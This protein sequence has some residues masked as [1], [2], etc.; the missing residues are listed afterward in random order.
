M[1]KYFNNYLSIHTIFKFKPI[2]F[3]LIFFIFPSLHKASYPP[4]IY[5]TITKQPTNEQKIRKCY[6]LYKST[7]I[8]NYIS[9]Y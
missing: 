2:Q 7:I 1:K 3:L 9:L 5:F 4:F 8:R 6:Y